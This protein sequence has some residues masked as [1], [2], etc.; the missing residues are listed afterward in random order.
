MDKTIVKTLDPTYFAK[1]DE[2]LRHLHILDTLAYES[3]EAQITFIGETIRNPK[4]VVKNIQLKWHASTKFSWFYNVKRSLLNNNGFVD[5]NMYSVS[6]NDEACN[7]V[8]RC[9]ITLFFNSLFAEFDPESSDL[10]KVDYRTFFDYIVPPSLSQSMEIW[11]LGLKLKTQLYLYK[12]RKDPLTNIFNELFP[13]EIEGPPI[14]KEA[15]INLRNTIKKCSG[16]MDALLKYFGWYTF[17]QEMFIFLSCIAGELDKPVLHKHT[18]IHKSPFSSSPSSTQIFNEDLLQQK[19]FDSPG[20]NAKKSRSSDSEQDQF[21]LM[22]DYNFGDYHKSG[23]VAQVISR[24]KTYDQN[25][26]VKQPNLARIAASRKPQR[27]SHL[28]IFGTINLS[29]KI[30]SGTRRQKNVE[31]CAFVLGQRNSS[32]QNLSEQKVVD[33]E[34]TSPESSFVEQSPSRKRIKGNSRKSIPRSKKRAIDNYL[35]IDD[36]V[37][38]ISTKRVNWNDEELRALEEGMREH[39]KAWSK[40]ERDYGGPGQ[41]LERRKQGQLKDKARSEYNRRQK[42]NIELG[43]FGIFEMD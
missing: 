33:D 29:P 20:G 16:D 18:S 34:Q 11:Q 15:H 5:I 23:E 28:G 2:F 39:G 42:D 24:E 41:V 40:I 8:R 10:S 12:M 32:I 37:V 22:V 31:S 30:N 4:N 14:Y 13:E 19:G 26:I 27:S 21:G 3:L 35:N 1:N 7:I 6:D 36:E 38:Q 43:V 9:N 17:T 25:L